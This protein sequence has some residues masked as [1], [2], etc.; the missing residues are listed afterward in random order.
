MD[1]NVH[2]QFPDTHLPLSTDRSWL[3]EPNMILSQ[4]EEI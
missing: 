3:E 2:G 1:V 4:A